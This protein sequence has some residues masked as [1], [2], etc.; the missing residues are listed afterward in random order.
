[1]L[2]ICYKGVYNNKAYVCKQQKYSLLCDKRRVKVRKGGAKI[3]VEIINKYETVFIINPELDEEKTNAVV[4]K[5]KSLIESAG[6]IDSIDVWGK[7]K[8]AYEI[9]DKTEGYYVLVNFSAKGD[10]PAELDRVYKITE[11]IMRS[12]IIRK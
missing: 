7:R 11:D 12:I 3:M 8:L 5:F 10:F 4:E 1:M 9:D 2:D 6:T